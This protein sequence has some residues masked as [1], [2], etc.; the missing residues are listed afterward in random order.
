MQVAAQRGL[1]G[2]ETLVKLNTLKLLILSS[3]TVQSLH[4]LYRFY[5]KNA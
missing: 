4:E 2:D 1:L 5:G 3:H